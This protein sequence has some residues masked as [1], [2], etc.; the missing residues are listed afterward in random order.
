M[1]LLKQF[2][3]QVKSNLI[4]KK[5]SVPMSFSRTDVKEEPFFPDRVERMSNDPSTEDLAT[6]TTNDE[7]V[8][9][10]KDRDQG[11]AQESR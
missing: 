7:T 3:S 2:F 4:G 8:H 9:V 5:E 10:A 6:E 11:S 1:F